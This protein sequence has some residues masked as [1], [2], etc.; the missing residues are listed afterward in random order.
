MNCSAPT[1]FPTPAR[2]VSLWPARAALLVCCGLLVCLPARPL[3]AQT[4]GTVQPPAAA[5]A[6]A[7][8]AESERDDGPPPEEEARETYLGRRVA[9]YMSHLG[10]GWLIRDS[11]KREEATDLVMKQLELEPGQLV[12]DMGC[13]NGYYTLRFARQVAP[14]GLV[15]AVDIQPEMLQMLAA[16]AARA[17]VDGVKP[18]QGEIANPNLPANELDMVFLADVY[19]EFSHPQSM[20]YWIRRSL[21][22]TGVVALLEYREED[23]TVQIKPLHKM[24]KDQ[25]MKEYQANGFKLV[26]EFNGLPMQH[27]MF[28][29]RDDSPLPAIEPQAWIFGE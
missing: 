27:L 13:G 8:A 25:I 7:T 19:H 26:R 29:A 28:F 14:R 10:A 17:R 21:K 6:K 24:S 12:C 22:P 2:A 20:L 23:P 1:L 11:R 16:R 9:Q 18:V 4:P 15:F 3:P 5:D